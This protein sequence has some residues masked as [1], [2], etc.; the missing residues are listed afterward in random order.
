MMVELKT[1]NIFKNVLIS[2]EKIHTIRR[3]TEIKIGDHICFSDE[4]HEFFCDSK[5]CTAMQEIIIWA[6]DQEIIIDQTPLTWEEKN[7]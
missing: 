4:N 1:L 6:E 3:E 7:S 5:E 2:G